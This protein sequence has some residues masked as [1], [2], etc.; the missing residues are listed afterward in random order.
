MP[1][2]ALNQGNRKV[3]EHLR[4]ALVGVYKSGKSWT[5]ATAPDPVLVLDLDLRADSLA[6]KEGV[7]TTSIAEP[8]GLNMQPTA[9]TETLNLIAK[10][11]KSRL[12]G[13]IHP[14]FKEDRRANENIKTLGLDSIQSMSRA[15]TQHNMYTNS[16]QLA[17][18]IKVAGQVLFFP[19]GWDTWN[20]DMECME[21]L[22]GRLAGIPEI[23]FWVTFH[24]DDPK[25]GKVVLYPKRHDNLLRYFNEVWRM[26]RISNVPVAQ[27]SPNQNFAATTTLQGTP[28]FVDNPN[29]KQLAAKYGKK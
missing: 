28:D 27:L 1:I 26:T 20:A 25:D 12:L 29:I 3:T 5:L 6:G 22:I 18:E 24:E 10:V 14:G 2:V 17:R 21:Q 9:Y 7:Y 4:G 15:I 16:K 23:D 11:E 8:A 13:D 19:S